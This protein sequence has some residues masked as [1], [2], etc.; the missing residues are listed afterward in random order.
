MMYRILLGTILLLLA[1]ACSSTRPMQV[2]DLEMHDLDTLFVEAPM[3]N[4]RKEA[5]DFRLPTYK[6]SAKRTNDLLHTKL[7]LSFDWEKEQVIGKAS[8]ELKP[9]FGS[10]QSLTLDAKQLNMNAIEIP[11]HTFDYTYDEEHIQITFEKPIAAKETYTVTIDYTAQPSASGG[12]AAITSN[13]GLFFINPRGEEGDKPQQIWTQGETEWNSR[14]FPTIDQ[15]NERCTQELFITVDQKFQTLSNGILKELTNNPDGTRTDHWQMDQPHA[16]YLF[17]LTVGEFAVVKDQWE[18]LPLTYYVEPKYENSAKAIFQHTP[19][20]IS[21]FSSKLNFP[22]PWD[23]YAQV[24][25]RDYVSGA[26]ENTT[27]SVFGERVQKFER[28]LIDDGNDRIVAHELFHQWF[29]NL[30]TCESWA[31]LTMNEGFANYAEY[32]WFEHKYGADEANYH[33]LSERSAYFFGSGMD[34]RPLIYF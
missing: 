15:P 8:L 10:V 13:Q 6:P 29:G 31:N 23:K 4:S 5:A 1:F 34:A 3:P 2:I 22:F 11:G 9:Y 32:L 7:E 14:W 18:D 24:V 25:V 17:M 26:M 27:A 28:A 19:E 12:S 30:V 16:P 33:L 20:M 21:F